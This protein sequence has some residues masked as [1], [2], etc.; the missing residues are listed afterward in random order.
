MGVGVKR[1][2]VEMGVTLGSG[3]N[4]FLGVAVNVGGGVSV[5]KAACV[6]RAAASAV[7]WINMLMSLE[8]S[9]G[10]GTG[11]AGTQARISTR[12][13]NQIKQFLKCKGTLNQF[14]F[15]MSARS[16]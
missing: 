15:L 10:M 7:C 8:F 14:D 12:A 3:V 6:C 9:V 16:A 2:K 13:P 11:V 4:V 5:G 1:T